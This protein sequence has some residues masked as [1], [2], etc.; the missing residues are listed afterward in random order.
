MTVFSLL[1]HLRMLLVNLSPVLYPLKLVIASLGSQQ[2]HVLLKSINLALNAITKLV[3]PI[4]QITC[5][6]SEMLIY[7]GLDGC[8]HHF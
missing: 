3:H 7:H 1:S 2:P 8:V 4:I 5:V 6:G